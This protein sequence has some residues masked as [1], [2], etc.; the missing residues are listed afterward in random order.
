MTAHWS[1]ALPGLW[2]YVGRY[3]HTWR[4]GHPV[5]R[6]IEHPVAEWHCAYGCT[7]YASGAEAVIRLLTDLDTAHNPS[8]PRL[9]EAPHV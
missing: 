1:A 7:R 2:V 9:L 8:C 6:W 3:T 4:P 5:G